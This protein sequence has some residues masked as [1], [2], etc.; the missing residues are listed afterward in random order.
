MLDAK[1]TENCKT[2]LFPPS[3]DVGPPAHERTDP[4]ISLLAWSGRVHPGKPSLYFE[5]VP[6]FWKCVPEQK[7][8][9]SILWNK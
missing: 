3:S 7:I 2:L 8:R 4:Q 5:N 6:V 1:D 9:W